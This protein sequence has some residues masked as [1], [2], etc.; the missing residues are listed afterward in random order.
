MNWKK[1]WDKKVN[2]LRRDL[3]T[4]KIYNFGYKTI[5]KDIDGS[6]EMFTVPDWGNIKNFIS[7]KIIEKLIEDIRQGRVYY[8]S[9]IEKLKNKWL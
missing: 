9:D 6:L 3:G 7:T 2:I 4:E 5:R 1:Q 8:D